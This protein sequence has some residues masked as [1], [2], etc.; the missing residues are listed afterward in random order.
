MGLSNIHSNALFGI[1]FGYTGAHSKC[2]ILLGE[3]RRKEERI[4]TASFGQTSS[5]GR[6]RIVKGE[7]PLTRG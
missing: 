4:F 7:I 5:T 2:T 3:R 1:D 6:I